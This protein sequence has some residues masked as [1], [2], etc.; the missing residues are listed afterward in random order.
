MNVYEAMVA[1][2]ATRAFLD[3]QVEQEKIRRILRHAARAPSGANTQPWH[4]AVVSGAVKR[5]IEARVEEAR[6]AG[7][8]GKAEYRYYPSGWREPYKSRRHACGMQLYRS[9]GI[10][11]G[12]K[13]RR[14]EQ[15][16]A[17]FR[18]FGAPVAMYFYIDSYLEVG[19]Y[20]DFGMF[21]Q[22]IMLAAIE[23]GL[24][25][26]PQAALGEYPAIV[27]SELRLEQ[28]S[29]LLCG[30][31]LGYEDTSAPVNGY[32]TPRMELEEFVNFHTD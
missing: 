31:A 28:G 6:R 32:R 20:L 12:D 11:R 19:S 27:K 8:L 9:Q 16:A 2:H 15:W 23:E 10:E 5:S 1:R 17:N 22:S 3:R 4:V 7:D 21:L 30:M 25:T 29:T 26:C 14:R 24:A 13:E 18:S